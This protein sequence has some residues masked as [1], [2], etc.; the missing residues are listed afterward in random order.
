MKNGWNF[1]QGTPARV[2]LQIIAT[3]SLGYS[4][5]LL[6]NA[7]NI[8]DLAKGVFMF[9]GGIFMFILREHVS[10]GDYFKEFDKHINEKYTNEPL[11]EDNKDEGLYG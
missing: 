11:P 6:N 7:E 1:T 10:N 2:S 9:I 5:L 4:I 3:G 8:F